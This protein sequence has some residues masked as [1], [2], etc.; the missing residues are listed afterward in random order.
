M[1]RSKLY[2][3]MI[4]AASFFGLARAEDPTTQYVDALMAL[5]DKCDK[6]SPGGPWRMDDESPKANIYVCA[7]HDGAVYWTADMDIDCDGKSTK[8]CNS[9]TDCCYQGQTAFQNSKGATLTASVDPYYV[10]PSNY[11]NSGIKGWQIAAIIDRT[12][13]KM[14]FAFEGDTGPNNIIGEASYATAVI[15]GINPDAKNGGSDGPIT[16]L[17]FTGSTGLP[18]V[19]ENHQEVVTVGMNAAKSWIDANGGS[20]K[21]LSEAAKNPGFSAGRNTIRVSEPGYHALRVTDVKGVTVLWETSFG[22]AAHDV[23]R[24]GSGVFFYQ[25]VTHKANGVMH[26]VS[27]H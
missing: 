18:K 15:L 14:T 5:T 10:I 26:K 13:K 6:H 21:I 2:V 17:V 24:L 22:P 20:T 23:S 25:V 16:Y 27:L 7:D 1:T 3:M 4:M 11:K 9:G 19:P 12:S 8:E